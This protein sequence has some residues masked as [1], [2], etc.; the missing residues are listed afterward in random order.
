MVF[1]DTKEVR[2]ATKHFVG[3]MKEHKSKI[4]VI[5]ND[6]KAN[7]TEKVYIRCVQV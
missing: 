5:D 7:D 3:N 4:V 1:L 6:T 2:E